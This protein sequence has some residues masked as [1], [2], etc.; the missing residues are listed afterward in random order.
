MYQAECRP[1]IRSTT[2]LSIRRGDQVAMG[3][4]G[5]VSFGHTVMKN[6]AIKVRQIYKD[7]VMVGFAG[8]TADAFTLFDRFEK[9]LETY[10]GNL[11]R[12]SIELAKDWRT[13][14]VL[15]RLEALLAVADSKSSLIISGTGDV[16]EPESDIMAIGSGGD[17]AKSAA[18]ALIK[19]TDLGAKK[20]VEAGLTIAADI[21]VY[22][23]HTFTILTLKA[24]S[25]G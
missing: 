12:S 15:R 7:Q 11:L 20:I 8:A 19:H 17:Y 2:I 6:N 21:C 10:Q 16:I 1:P 24:E 9:K 14:K 18:T 3:G 25:K 23:N 22:T 5:Q 13:D 4:D